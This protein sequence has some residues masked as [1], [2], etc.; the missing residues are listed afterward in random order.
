[1]ENGDDAVDLQVRVDFFFVMTKKL[2]VLK[3]DRRMIFLA[4][5]RPLS[6]VL[7]AD[8]QVVLS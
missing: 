4:Y 1:V 6:P 3:A 7:M 2:I 5:D 8:T